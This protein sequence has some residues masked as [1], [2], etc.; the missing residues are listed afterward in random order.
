MSQTSS[1]LLR[2]F[3]ISQDLIFFPNSFSV[4]VK[5]TLKLNEPFQEPAEREL[6]IT[7]PVLVDVAP[8]F[9][10]EYVNSCFS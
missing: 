6:A 4:L 9:K 7:F 5:V 10:S 1:P 2:S 3:E 8:S